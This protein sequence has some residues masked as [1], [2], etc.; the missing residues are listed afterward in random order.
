MSRMIIF[1]EI[2]SMPSKEEEIEAMVKMQEIIHKQTRKMNTLIFDFY[3]FPHIH[4]E[5]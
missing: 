1:F 5:N 4:F 2:G 3:F